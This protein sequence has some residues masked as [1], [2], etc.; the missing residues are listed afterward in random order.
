MRRIV[1]LIAVAVAALAVSGL[2]APYV[3]Q[4][5][6]TLFKIATRFGV[7]TEELRRAN[8]LES[9]NLRVGQ[10]LEVPSPKANAPLA[11]KTTA[12]ADGG[13]KVTHRARF[14]PGD[15]VLVRVSG[16][17]EAPTVTWG[18]GRASVDNPGQGTTGTLQEGE[19]TL[20]MAKDGNDWVGVGRDILG[21]PAE[22]VRLEVRAGTQTV[23][24]SLTLVPD[25]KVPRDVFMSQAVMS[26]LTD[27]N[28]AKER[29]VLQAAHRQAALTPKAWT[30]P[31]AWP[32][33]DRQIS[34]FAQARFY[35]KGGEVN[36]HYGEDLFGRVGDPIRAV[37]DGTVVIAG[38]YKIR[39]GMVGID[40]GAGVVSLYFHQ[41]KIIA[42][43]GQK[44]ARGA[45]I[46]L[47]GNTGFSTGAHLHL[48]MRV[49]GEATD[50][51]QWINRV[52]PQ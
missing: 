44:V 20:V 3:V 42:K 1:K 39:G 21:T 46:G 17:T 11:L 52:W 6:D 50:P 14:T 9:D 51:R 19:M 23:A 49:R 2:A 5:G 26:T 24:S 7:S 31:W 33:P 34:P 35:E 37:N 36:Y 41:S 27:E 48:E 47:V 25:P 43:V 45:V 22:T 12:S 10:V 38:F 29:A 8:S 32:V 30:K 4:P 15:P 40:H 16:A 18:V 13:L 28:R